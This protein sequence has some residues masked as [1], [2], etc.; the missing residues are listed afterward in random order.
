MT[1]ERWIDD[2]LLAPVLRYL[3]AK[4]R[5]VQAQQILE[6]L[7]W[8]E[9][10]ERSHWKFQL[11]QSAT[12]LDKGEPKF[13][14]LAHMLVDREFT[15]LRCE[16]SKRN[17]YHPDVK[18][19]L[20]RYVQQVHAATLAISLTNR[21]A[22][23]GIQVAEVPEIASVITHER[24]RQQITRTVADV[25]Q[26]ANDP[27]MLT[28][29]QINNEGRQMLIV[30]HQASGLRASFLPQADGIG[31]VFSKPYSIASI[32]TES[33]VIPEWGMVLGL[34]IGQRIYEHGAVRL[35][36]QRW[37]SSAASDH[38]RGLRRKLHAQDPHRWAS[39][40]CE[41]CSGQGID[42]RSAPTSKF[43]GHPPS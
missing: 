3:D 6:D 12:T 30:Q 39:P 35:G 18:N 1:R 42:W 29:E 36:N 11:Q 26:I 31:V 20:D 5:H 7:R 25:A 23:Q 8:F 17:P 32:D 27:V 24:I 37:A 4:A 22:R 40:S 9:F 41:W 14:D 10:G 33:T 16:Q 43:L 2:D 38:A 21:Y 15:A 34:G 28:E 19:T 13:R